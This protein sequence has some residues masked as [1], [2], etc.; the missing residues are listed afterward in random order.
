MKLFRVKY[1]QTHGSVQK[2]KQFND[3]NIDELHDIQHS[4]LPSRVER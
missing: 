2:K 1:L 3:T 4:Q